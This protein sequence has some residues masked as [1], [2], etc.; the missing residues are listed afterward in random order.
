MPGA[1]KLGTG[2]GCR[3]PPTQSWSPALGG[4]WGAGV[5]SAAP[6]VSRGSGVGVAGG[7]T[8]TDLRPVT[9]SA[10]GARVV[11]R[12]AMVGASVN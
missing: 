10:R 4:M 8:C 6:C 11:S 3:A 2:C 7:G 1:S 5:R 9:G 12:A